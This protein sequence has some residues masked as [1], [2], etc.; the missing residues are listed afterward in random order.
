M[1]GYTS[2]G[3]VQATGGQERR[4]SSASGALLPLLLLAG[5]SL[6]AALWAGLYR[7][8]W[9]LPILG[10]H[11][12]LAHGPLLVGGF[13]GT[14]I[15]LEK[16]RALARWWGYLAPGCAAAGGVALILGLPPL[17]PRVSFLLAAAIL[18]LVFASLLR[19][20]PDA[21]GALMLAGAAAW[22]AGNA[23]WLAGRSVPVAAFWW[24]A[25]PVLVIVGERLELSRFTPR[26]AGALAALAAAL[27]IYV[28]GLLAS[29]WHLDR[30]LR[31]QG[32]GLLLTAAWLLR[33]DLARRTLR[34][35]GVHRYSACCLLS[36]FLWLA[37]GGGLALA[38]GADLQGWRYDAL[39]H[40]ILLGFVFG[41]VF[42]HAPI[43]AP[44]LLGRRLAFD[45]LFYAPW[46]LLQASLALR[47]AADLSGW[48]AG[49]SWA[50][51]GNAA[52]LL[53]FLGS[54]VRGVRRGAR[55]E[56]DAAAGFRV[57]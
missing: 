18:V 50:A 38:W 14:L 51:M 31:V 23:L 17:V 42:G 11:H 37:A 35:A 47:L 2:L 20:L 57:P 52:A 19:R 56:R 13:L 22:L 29:P 44:M 40:T 48:Q 43:V 54:T 36:G 12:P 6:L 21:A 45:R 8:G 1:R 3:V 33:F 15:G 32:L 25:F 55:G 9:E 27:A 28:A 39:L 16:A 4:G 26:P 41:M 49:R 46:L 34:A 10:A 24:L 7:A 30:A 5:A 53:L